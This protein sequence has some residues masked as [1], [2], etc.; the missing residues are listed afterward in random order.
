ML[1][2]LVPVTRTVRDTF[3][4]A[5][6]DDLIARLE[7]GDIEPDRKQQL[8]TMAETAIATV[9]TET[10]TPGSASAPAVS[11]PVVDATVTAAVVEEIREMG[12]ERKTVELEALIAALECKGITPDTIR[13]ALKTLI[14]DGD[15]YQPKPN[16]IRLF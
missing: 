8:V 15:C 1:E 16:L 7:V 5:A 3:V 9:I 2:T 13:A 6:A 11:E 14:E 12:D 10:P 4:L